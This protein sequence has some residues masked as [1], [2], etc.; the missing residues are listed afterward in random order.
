MLPALPSGWKTGR[1]KGLKA[2]GGFMVDIK[3]KNN[4][5]VN[6]M[7]YSEQRKECKIR[8]KDKVIE[9]TVEKGEFK[10]LDPTNFK[11]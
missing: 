7:I 9:I 5:L 3:W 8:Y 4:K 2:R 1:V 11:L 10:T 6:A